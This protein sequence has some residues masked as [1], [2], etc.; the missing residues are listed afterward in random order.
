LSAGLPYAR[1]MAV[2]VALGGSRAKVMAL[3]LGESTLL[4]IAGG[5][6][7]VGGLR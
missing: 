5:A 4:A 3:L 1:E 6:L 7:G 2:R